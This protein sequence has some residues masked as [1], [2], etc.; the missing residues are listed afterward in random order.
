[1]LVVCNGTILFR[2]SLSQNFKITKL[3]T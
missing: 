3:W 1:V 2:R